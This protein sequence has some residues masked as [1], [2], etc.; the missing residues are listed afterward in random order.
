MGGDDRLSAL[1]AMTSKFALDLTVTFDETQQKY[2][3]HTIKA[4]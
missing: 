2:R 1:Q 3:A 4:L